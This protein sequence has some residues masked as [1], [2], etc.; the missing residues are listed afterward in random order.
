MNP[1]FDVFR[2]QNE[3]FIKWVGTVASLGDAEALIQTDSIPIN[4]SEDD[5]VV[6]HSAYGVTEMFPAHSP[7]KK[8]RIA[9]L[10]ATLTGNSSFD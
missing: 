6:V 7:P 8:L 5:Y 4:A 1:R 2:K 3:H 10:A 9:P